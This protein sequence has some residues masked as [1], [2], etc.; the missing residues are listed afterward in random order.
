MCKGSFDDILGPASATWNQHLE[1]LGVFESF[2][3]VRNLS[4]KVEIDGKILEIRDMQ[5]I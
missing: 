1:V 3:E 5:G 2:F 4:E